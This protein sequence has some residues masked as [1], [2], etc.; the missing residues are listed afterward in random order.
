MKKVLI[1]LLSL[2]L[3][4][5]SLTGCS[6]MS[7]EDVSTQDQQEAKD[8]GL[9]SH[10]IGVAT[11]NVRDA[12]IM[13][14]KE[15]LDGYIKECF[16]DVSFLYSDSLSGSEDLMDF[17]SFCAESG[18][19]GVMLFGSYDLQKEAAFCAENEMY[20]IRPSATSS[21]EDFE[22][23]ASNPYYVGEI[24]PGT[25]ME[26]KAGADMAE[27]LAKEGE[28][29]LIFSSGAS[30]ENEMHRLRTLGILDTLQKIYGV[31]FE[32]SPEELAV[33]DEPTNV[34]AGDLKFTI[35]PGYLESEENS[36]AAAG[37]AASGE[38]TTIL[39]TVPVSPIKD[40][41]DT[42]D[43]HCG[44][45][46]CFSEDNYYGF[47]NG[48]ISYVAGKYQSEIG[49][50]FAALYNA[51]TGNAEMFREDGRAF[52]LE[53]GF[54]IA[55]SS[56]EYSEMYSLARSVSVNAYNYEDL[57]GVIRSMTPD[58]DFEDLRALAESY[59]YEDCMERRGLD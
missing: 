7:T 29:Y 26:Y 11:Y 5:S 50:G 45:I 39:S 24:G 28:T 35:F 44:A 37:L 38:Y 12:Q 16:P 2:V 33:V 1:F 27:T 9:E 31:E 52:R 8:S 58:A 42:L 3:S 6:G 48:T 14:F 59:S 25:E 46:D 23:V 19:E 43:I 47:R 40:T 36:A 10:K 55:E 54:W 41:L 49:P 22:A 20:M 17:L 51:V 53:Q 34:E 32:Q 13:M 4:F 21:D 56:E 15:Y 18:V 30:E 57:Y